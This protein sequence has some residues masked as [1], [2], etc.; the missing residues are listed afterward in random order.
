MVYGNTLFNNYYNHMAPLPQPPSS[1]KKVPRK[2]VPQGPSGNE[3][4]RNSGQDVFRPLARRFGF[5]QQQ[6]II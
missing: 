3:S 4:V 6:Q 1:S 2:P 5:I